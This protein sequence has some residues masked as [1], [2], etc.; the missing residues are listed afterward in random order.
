ML[1]RGKSK[2]VIGQNIATEIN[3][4]R[5]RDQAIAIAMSKAGKS[6]RKKKPR[7]LLA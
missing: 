6:K 5:P 3:A 1:K 4:G 7:G 2:Q